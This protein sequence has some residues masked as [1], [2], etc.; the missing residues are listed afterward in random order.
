[1]ADKSVDL[2]KLL[3]G[4]GG[5]ITG[6]K[7]VKAVTT[8]PDK[9]TF[10]FEGTKLALPLDIF[11]VPVNLY[12]IKKDDRFIAYPIVTTGAASRWALIQKINGCTVNMATMQGPSSLKIDGIDK[13]YAVGDLV[14]PPFVVVSKDQDRHAD[15]DDG[16]TTYSP[17]FLLGDDKVVR[18][19]KIGDR[20]SV[21]PTWDAAGKKIKYAVLQKY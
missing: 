21:A 19:L 9:I 10:I 3:W 1:M 11:E 20:V 6:V 8:E 2:L 14:I 15:T 16:S 17:Y 12:P 7:V 4:N 18:A 5:S 13:V